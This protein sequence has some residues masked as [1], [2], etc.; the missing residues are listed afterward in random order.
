MCSII[1]IFTKYEW[2]LVYHIIFLLLTY[3]TLIDLRTFQQ[4]LMFG[5]TFFTE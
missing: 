2:F 3:Y 1:A 5:T 4:I